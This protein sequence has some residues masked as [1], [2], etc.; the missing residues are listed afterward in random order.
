MKE[1]LGRLRVLRCEAERQAERLER[2][3]EEYAATLEALQHQAWKDM[4]EEKLAI[5]REQRDEEARALQAI[6]AARRLRSGKQNANEDE[7]AKPPPSTKKAAPAS[8]PSKRKKR[9]RRMPTQDVRVE[10]DR[11]SSDSRTP[12]QTFE[13]V[14]RPV[15][16]PKLRKDLLSKQK[17]VK[18]VKAA[19]LCKLELRM[20]GLGLHSVPFPAD[21]PSKREALILRGEEKQLVE[22]LDEVS[23]KIRLLPD[24]S[25]LFCSYTS[26]KTQRLNTKAVLGILFEQ[27]FKMNLILE[28]GE[29][30]KARRDRIERLMKQPSRSEVSLNFEHWEMKIVIA[31]KRSFR[32]NQA[33][34]AKQLQETCTDPLRSDLQRVAQAACIPLTFERGHEFDARIFRFCWRVLAGER[35]TLFQDDNRK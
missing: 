26:G 12:D 4:V 15:E 16:Y 21:A 22:L 14:A 8:G 35:K 28:R 32:T 33:P 9:S 31:A 18:D 10:E 2:V 1:T 34:S 24:L 5:R 13:R 17:E 6:Q 3:C 27:W 20:R 29:E 25:S 23:E 19:V 11:G 30:L 7:L